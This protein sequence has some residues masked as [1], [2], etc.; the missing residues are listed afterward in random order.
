[1]SGLVTLDI[2]NFWKTIKD[3]LY[4]FGYVVF[5]A[6]LIM[7][8]LKAQYMQ[9]SFFTGNNNTKIHISNSFIITLNLGGQNF[10]VRSD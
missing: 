2:K 6:F 3:C 9:V 5:N 4:V 1:M 7:L 10:F 8:L